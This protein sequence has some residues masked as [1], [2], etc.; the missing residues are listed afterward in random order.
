MGDHGKT[1]KTSTLEKATD[2]RSRL[3]VLLAAASMLGLSVGYVK[4]ATSEPVTSAPAD[5][6][7]SNIVGTQP[8][9]PDLRLA[10]QLPKVS[11][12]QIHVKTGTHVNAGVNSSSLKIRSA[13]ANFLKSNNINSKYYKNSGA[14]ANFLK[15]DAKSSHQKVYDANSK[16]LKYTGPSSNYKK[17]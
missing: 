13:N 15:Y 2:K 16:Y 12:P 1:H 17:Y 9:M 14:N 10:E 6:N 8:A 4:A 5:S 3:S 11:T 7:G